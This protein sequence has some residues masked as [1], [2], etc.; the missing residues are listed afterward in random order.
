MRMWPKPRIVVSKCLE[1]EH[2]R[3]NAE[4]ITSEIVRALKP[5]TEFIPVCPEVEVGLGVPRDPIRVVSDHGDLRLIQPSTGRDI[6]TEMQGFSERFLSSVGSVD[7]F[8][9]K[10]R[11]PS[12]GLK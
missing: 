7:G 1:F 4:I 12:C 2:C 5:F 9:L 11:S 3:Y 6:T 10:T 8:V